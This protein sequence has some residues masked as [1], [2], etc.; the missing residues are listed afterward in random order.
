MNR[1]ELWVLGW[2]QIM[3]GVIRILTLGF[4]GLGLDYRYCMWIIERKF[5]R[6]I[7]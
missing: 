1:C 3:D 7:K 6:R 5:E 4:I 2:I